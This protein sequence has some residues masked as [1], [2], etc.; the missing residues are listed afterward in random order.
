MATK[1][2]EPK[3]TWIESVCDVPLPKDYAMT[4]IVFEHGK[5]FWHLTFTGGFSDEGIF[6]RNVL[7]T[8]GVPAAKRKESSPISGIFVPAHFG[9]TEMRSLTKPKPSGVSA[10][11]KVD[12]LNPK[13]A[14]VGIT[15]ITFLRLYEPFSKVYDAHQISTKS[16]PPMAKL[17]SKA[18]SML[19]VIGESFPPH[20]EKNPTNQRIYRITDFVRGDGTDLIPLN[21]QRIFHHPIRSK[22]GLDYLA[23]ILDW[24][25]V[26]VRDVSGDY[27]EELG[28]HLVLSVPAIRKMID[29]LKKR[30]QK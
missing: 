9:L 28:S 22:E 27:Y 29:L 8:F 1:K 10:T 7:W 23:G 4:Q 2:T 14:E 17:E 12:R 21:A 19:R 16:I 11:F 5:S 25:K 26:G 24:S 3:R 30:E 13:T 18:L 6:S 15:E 20:H